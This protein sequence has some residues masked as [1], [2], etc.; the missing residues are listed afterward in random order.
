LSSCLSRQMRGVDAKQILQGL[1]HNYYV[2][3]KG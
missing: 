3:P 1:R 2:V